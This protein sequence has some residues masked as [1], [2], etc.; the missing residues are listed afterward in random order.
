MKV[1][2]ILVRMQSLLAMLRQSVSILILVNVN[3]ISNLWKGVSCAVDAGSN[4]CIGEGVIMVPS[5]WL[6]WCRNESNSGWNARCQSATVDHY[7]IRHHIYKVQN[8]INEME[9]W[10]TIVLWNVIIIFKMFIFYYYFSYSCC[11][12]KPDHS[13]DVEKPPMNV[14]PLDSGSTGSSTISSRWCICS[15]TSHLIIAVITKLILLVSSRVHAVV[16][17]TNSI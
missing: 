11:R 17:S 5:W 4:V 2:S 16:T 1:T 7:C 12:S 6:L 13:P 15:A 3:F 8:N 14:G 10:H 9:C